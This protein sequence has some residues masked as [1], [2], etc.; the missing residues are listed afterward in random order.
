MK[1]IRNYHDPFSASYW[2]VKM[3]NNKPTMRE[4]WLEL[5]DEL[6]VMGK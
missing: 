6:G 4:S 1:R 2:R 3:L 5:C